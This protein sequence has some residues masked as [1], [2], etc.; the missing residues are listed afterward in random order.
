MLLVSKKKRPGFPKRY[1]N[2]G[3]Q[4]FSTSSVWGKIGYWDYFR[5]KTILMQ[6]QAGKDLSDI[7]SLSIEEIMDDAPPQIREDT[8]IT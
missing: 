7:S 2:G 4:L 6:L 1:S 3:S 5:K 8:P